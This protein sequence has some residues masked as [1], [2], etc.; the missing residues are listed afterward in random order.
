MG[1]IVDDTIHFFAKYLR[2]RRELGMSPEDAI[3]YAFR[4]VGTA[5]VVTS[6]ILIC[7]FLILATSAFT[8]NNGMS[9]LTAIA[10]ATALIADFALLPPLILLIERR[11]Q[12]KTD[13]DTPANPDMETTH[14]PA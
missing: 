11:R 1:I 8:P 6:I 13:T 2:A 10:I 12:G 3:P 14:A 5:L 9:Q 7:G 4:T